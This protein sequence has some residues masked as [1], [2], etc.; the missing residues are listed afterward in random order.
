MQNVACRVYRFF[1]FSINENAKRN[2]SRINM[3]KAYNSG[4]TGPSD[5]ISYYLFMNI[6]NYSL[7]WSSLADL[8]DHLGDPSTTR[9][10]RDTSTGFPLFFWIS[11]SMQKSHLNILLLEHFF[12]K[13]SEGR[14]RTYRLTISR[15]NSNLWITTLRASIQTASIRENED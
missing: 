10:C 4:N 2:I 7:D 5:S 11:I 13:R 3:Y 12:P 15:R 9:H 14:L 8:C 1:S 6:Y